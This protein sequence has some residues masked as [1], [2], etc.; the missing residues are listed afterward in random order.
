MFKRD[1]SCGFVGNCIFNALRDHT[2]PIFLV[3]LQLELGRVPSFVKSFLYFKVELFGRFINLDPFAWVITIEFI[4]LGKCIVEDVWF[5]LLLWKF[6]YLGF[7]HCIKW[8]TLIPF[9]IRN[10]WRNH[11]TL[12]EGAATIEWLILALS[13]RN[14]GLTLLCNTV[15]S[16]LLLLFIIHWCILTCI[17]TWQLLHWRVLLLQMQHLIFLN[18]EH[19][20]VNFLRRV[21][22]IQCTVTPLIASLLDNIFETILIL[23][24]HLKDLL[25]QLSLF[26]SGNRAVSLCW[27]TIETLS[28]NFSF[29]CS[30]LSFGELL[31]IQFVFRYWQPPDTVKNVFLGRFKLVFE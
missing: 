8:R 27:E 7:Y 26:L 14:C 17:L 18:T 9:N 24:L 4:S 2:R 30:C 28:C 12:R 10:E 20:S 5:G 31:V 19:L 29:E 22:Q 6:H 1:H 13:F 23:V 3:Y 25:L 16:L 15:E 11:Y 21:N